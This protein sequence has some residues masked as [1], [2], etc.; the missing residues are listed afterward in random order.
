MGGIAGW[1][2]LHRRA[3]DEGALAGMLSAVAHRFH[4]ETELHAVADRG[5]RQQAVL[6]AVLHDAASGV[7]IALDGAIANAQEL[8]GILAKRGHAFA[9]RSDAGG[10]AELLLRAYQHWDKDAVKQLRGAFALALWDERKERLLLAR[11]R[12]GEKPLYLRGGEGTL[13]FASEPRSLLQAGA[14]PRVDASALHECLVHGRVT[15][16]R[17]LFEGIRKLAP[18]SYLL[19]QLGRLHEAH[20]WVAPDRDPVPE[21]R[22]ATEAQ[23]VEG[24][25]AELEAVV[26]GEA[27][28]GAGLFLSG[29]LDSAVLGALMAKQ[30]G[31]LSTFSLGFEGEEKSELPLAAQLAQHFGAR[32][33]EVVAAPRDLPALLSKLIAERGAPLGRPS[34]LALHALAAEAGRSVTRVLTGEG[35]DEVLGGYRRYLAAPLGLQDTVMRGS[36]EI[37]LK[38][39]RPAQSAPAEGDPHASPLRRALYRD[40]TGSLP[41]DLLE[42]AD[43]AGAAAG[44]DLRAP[45]LDH[46]LAERVSAEPDAMRVRGLSTKWI[47]RR[48]AEGLLPAPLRKGPK[49]GFRPP[50]AAWL[51]GELREPLESHL[52]SADSAIREH[53]HARALD[54]VLDEHLSSKKNHAGVLWT[55][56]NI[57]IWHRTCLRP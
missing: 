32:H 49:R 45:Y 8:R 1:V 56:L 29:G 17:T 25:L 10:D 19:W 42:R 7:S 13:H 16:S 43:R 31:T 40:Q 21:R 2:A 14:A 38:D 30:G 4:A 34:D 39:P 27:A 3:L 33:H 5:A 11:D 24:F 53:C 50:V 9:A 54:R 18:G 41:D 48:A 6:G 12:F 15:G 37:I 51:R 23:A 20:Y 46:R 22:D 55:L 36:R 26:K 35:C 47:L 52:R 44:V 28:R 57:E